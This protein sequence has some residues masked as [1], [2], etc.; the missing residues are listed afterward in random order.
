M[1]HLSTEHSTQRRP[2]DTTMFW[3]TLVLLG[4][5]C[6]ARGETSAL[7][8]QEQ[9]VICNTVKDMNPHFCAKADSADEVCH[10]LASSVKGKICRNM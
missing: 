8:E 6:T 9:D 7:D 1:N 10:K 2:E 5:I 4:S 3:V